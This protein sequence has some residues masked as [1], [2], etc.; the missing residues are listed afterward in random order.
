MLRGDAAVMVVK[1]KVPIV[2][3]KTLSF[4]VVNIRSTLV[5]GTALDRIAL[6]GL[7]TLSTLRRLRI[8]SARKLRERVVRE[9]PRTGR[10]GDSCSLAGGAMAI[11]KGSE[12]RSYRIPY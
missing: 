7:G 4:V 1:V 12:P 5:P 11:G 10:R 6:E 8:R 2:L 3:L 9:L